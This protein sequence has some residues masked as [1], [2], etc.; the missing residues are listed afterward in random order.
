MTVEPK[1]SEVQCGLR[2][3]EITDASGPFVARIEDGKLVT[4]AL[5]FCNLA[6]TA[7]CPLYTGED[8][9]DGVPLGSLVLRVEAFRG[10]TDFDG[11]GYKQALEMQRTTCIAL[12]EYLETE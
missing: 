12:R 8:P 2:P 3:I 11:E 4:E 5:A 7:E 1:S 9:R 6:E 10:S